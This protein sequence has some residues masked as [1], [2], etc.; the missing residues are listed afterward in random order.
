MRKRHKAL[1]ISG[2]YQLRNKLLLQAEA[3]AQNGDQPIIADLN[4]VSAQ[5]AARSLAEKHRCRAI[6]YELDVANARSV[7]TFM[8][9]VI[10]KWGSIDVI[11]NNAGLQHIDPVEHFPVQNGIY[12]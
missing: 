2:T 1:R 6:A 4:L 12:C 3:F 7:E 8:Q 11:I 10:Q 9:K 5:E